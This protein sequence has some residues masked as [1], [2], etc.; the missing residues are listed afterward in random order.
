MLDKKIQ[1]KPKEEVYVKLT[2]NADWEGVMVKNHM[3]LMDMGSVALVYLDDYF[4]ED[5]NRVL[6]AEHS[7]MLAVLEYCTN[8]EVDKNT[9]PAMLSDYA[10]WN[11]IKKRILNYGDFRYLLKQTVEEIKE[12]TREKNS[13][14]NQ[15]EKVTEKII[16]LVDQLANTELTPESLESLKESL[17][18]INSSPILKSIVEKVM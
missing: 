1:I 13:F 14:G 7:L 12:E 16:A 8:I 6:Y 2:G 4:S 11:E 10:L 9:I 17:S 5:K 15:F 3:S 18:E